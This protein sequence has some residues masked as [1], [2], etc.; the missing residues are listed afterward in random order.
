MKI[1]NSDKFQLQEWLVDGKL[2]RISNG[3]LIVSL[4]PK[5]MAILLLLIEADGELVSNQEVL[6]Q[7]WGDVSV[8]LD[9]VYYSLSQLLKKLSDHHHTPK[10]IETIPKCGYRLIAPFSPIE[11]NNENNAEQNKP[12]SAVS[13]SDGI[14]SQLAATLLSIWSALFMHKKHLSVALTV[15]I[16]A[17]ISVGLFN[18]NSND[19]VRH[20]M[21]T[22]ATNKVKPMSAIAVIPF[23]DLSEKSD[24]GYFAAGISD[25]LANQ[26]TQIKGIKVA[27]P[28]SSAALKSKSMSISE[29]GQ[30]L[31]VGAIVE[32]SVRLH[33]NQ[34]L[35]TVQLID[36]NSGYQIWSKVYDRKLD[37]LFAV[38]D[39]ISASVVA[40][41]LPSLSNRARQNK[42]GNNSQQKTAAYLL[43]LRGVDAIK[44]NSHHALGQAMDY[45]NRSIELDPKLSRAY[46]ELAFAK[47]LYKQTGASND[48]TLIDQAQQ[49]LE[50]AI[51]LSA[52]DGRT[53]AVYAALLHMKSQW[54]Q[55]LNKL[56]RAVQLS[57]E[58]GELK[59]QLAISIYKKQPLEAEQLFN[60]AIQSDP[61]N[62]KVRILYG[63]FLT[64][65]GKKDKAYLSFKHATELNPE[66]PNNWWQLS[67]NLM[68]EHGRIS[69]GLKQLR[70]GI[71]QDRNDIELM[72]FQQMGYLTLGEAIDIKEEDHDSY[73]N[74]QQLNAFS[75]LLSA[76]DALASGNNELAL[77]IA[78]EAFAKEDVRF[79]HGT[80]DLLSRIITNQLLAQNKPLQAEAFLHLNHPFLVQLSNPNL[81]NEKPLKKLNKT[82]KGPSQAK[83]ILAY[84]DTLRILNK[85][86]EFEQLRETLNS[87]EVS[88][89]L[90][91]S[92]NIRAKDYLIQA[93]LSA[94]RGQNSTAL[95]MLKNS[96]DAGFRLNWQ[97]EIKNNYSFRG[98]YKDPR[99]IKQIE[100]LETDMIAQRNQLN[101]ENQLVTN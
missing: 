34:V 69:D 53:Y 63:H 41:V 37:S 29:I 91:T 99:F 27:S 62:D 71:Q 50:K 86:T 101:L 93:E 21:A 12:Q 96:I 32:G 10:Y 77:E 25:E 66:N 81:A 70:T 11:G 57:P 82:Y 38:Q 19:A 28:T 20:S 75:F 95:S 52:N 31:N 73:R 89:I 9:S 33:N 43:Y 85:E 98:L 84:A 49:H 64:K 30:L 2:N 61:L 55:G 97:L 36:T 47:L 94:I 46:T 74:Q 35:I 13:D 59:A 39:E 48:A 78:K 18:Q 67:L 3:D 68:K 44:I 17:T 40:A 4:R 24:Q 5:E 76:L 88:N 22:I 14:K 60:E 100:R 15:T 80:K 92:A 58:D 16:L 6:E 90:K 83:L 51:E 79:S 23:T 1:D 42:R 7:V 45:L 72:F 8:N 54:Q 56:K 26:L 65:Q 87:L